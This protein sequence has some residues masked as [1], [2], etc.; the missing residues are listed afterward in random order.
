[1]ARKYI[2]PQDE[3]AA[4]RYATKAPFIRGETT[5]WHNSM[6]GFLAGI[7]YARKKQR[8]S[9]LPSID[10]MPVLAGINHNI[11]EQKRYEAYSESKR[12]V[13]RADI[14]YDE[15]G[16]Q[17][18]NPYCVGARPNHMKVSNVESEITCKLCKKFKRVR[19]RKV[20]R[21]DITYDE[22]GQ[23]VVNP[24]CVGA[25]PN[26]MKVSRIESE[27]TCK[28]CK[29]FKRVRYRSGGGK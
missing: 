1:M 19:Y 2:M 22:S 25:R 15:S 9:E 20:H 4:M 8:L 27:I 7:R 26:H 17:I 21:A 18:V 10:V 29:K 16:Q 23:Q 14:T 12:K 6:N 5:Y 13:H 3:D 28:L 24:Y 11:G